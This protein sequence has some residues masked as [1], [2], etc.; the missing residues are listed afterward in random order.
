MLAQDQP[1]SHGITTVFKDYGLVDDIS[2]CW[3]SKAKGGQKVRTKVLV[4]SL[5]D[6]PKVNGRFCARSN[7]GLAPAEWL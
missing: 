1:K 3:E 4:T 6:D 7:Q 2:I 5:M